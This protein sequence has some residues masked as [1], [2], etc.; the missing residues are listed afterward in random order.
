[1][2]DSKEYL[3][4]QLMTKIPS[5]IAIE[6]NVHERTITRKMQKFGL[7]KLTG[8]SWTS[9]EITLLKQNYILNQNLHLLFP[10]RNFSSVYHKANRLGLHRCMRQRRYSVNENFFKKWTPEMAYV[11]GFFCADGLFL[12]RKKKRFENHLI[13]R[14]DISDI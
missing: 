9:S 8:K 10:H 4:G 1:M 6:H 13:Q 2:Y 12:K 14:G 3:L 5:Q 11:F 7:T